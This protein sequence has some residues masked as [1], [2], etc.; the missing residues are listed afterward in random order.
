MS[1]QL[2][3]GSQGDPQATKDVEK[4][5]DGRQVLDAGGIDPGL[6]GKLIMREDKRAYAPVHLDTLPKNAQPATLA[7]HM[8]Y[9][10]A[11]SPI[12]G[13]EQIVSANQQAALLRAG[14][15]LTDRLSALDAKTS[16]SEVAR[17]TRD[18]ALELRRG[19]DMQLRAITEPYDKADKLLRRWQDETARA[20]GGS[21]GLA[22]MVNRLLSGAVTMAE[23]VNAFND[24][25]RLYLL[26]A[27]LQATIEVIAQIV[28]MC[29]RLTSGM[30]GTR[31]AALSG[32]QEAQ[33]QADQVMRNMSAQGRVADYVVDADRVIAVGA[34]EDSIAA[35]LPEL[36]GEAR[37]NG[38]ANVVKTAHTI[39]ARSIATTLGALDLTELFKREAAHT[40]VL[41]KTVDPERAPLIVAAH[42]LDIARRKRPGLRLANNARAREYVLQIGSDT[43]PLFA[44]PSLIAA[45]FT[46][47]HHELAFM[48]VFTDVALDELQ[49]M[50][51]GVDEFRE[52]LRKREFFIIEEIAEAWRA[53]AGDADGA[54]AVRN[55]IAN[56]V[57][58]TADRVARPAVNGNGHTAQDV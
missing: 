6:P 45:R 11:P 42:V 8:R 37:D 49:V 36:I 20:T 25:E 14:Q 35:G 34:G 27:T 7:Q 51:E 50:R 15:S 21:G 40:T 16:F 46:R 17:Q 57:E 2:M 28:A 3:F 19:F 56:T 9:M 54:D 31:A 1:T 23:A 32:A 18:A 24:R 44:H 43:R 33:Q 55:V 48:R 22:A 52:A 41:G 53:D 29:E 4:N 5:T 58:L 26:R 38:G 47:P 30:E 12:G 13:H 10:T 39:A